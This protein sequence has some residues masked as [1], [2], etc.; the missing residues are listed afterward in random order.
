MIT[1]L[2]TN[3]N[4]LIHQIRRTDQLK[5]MSSGLDKTEDT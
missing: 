4:A 5:W 3:S 1:I 2:F